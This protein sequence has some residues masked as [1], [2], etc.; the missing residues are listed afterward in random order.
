[1]KLTKF[2][3]F[4]DRRLKEGITNCKKLFLEIK[5]QGF[6]GSYFS[7]YRYSKLL[8]NKTSKVDNRGFHRFE[9]PPGEQAQVDWGS[10]KTIEIN[11]RLERLYCFVYLLGYS[12]TLYIEFAVKK[13]LKTFQQCHMQVFE[14]LG[15]PKNILYDNVKTVVLKREKLPDGTYKF[16]YNPAFLDFSRYYGFTIKLCMPYWPRTKG[17]IESGVKFVRNNFMQGMKFNNGFSSLEELNKRALLWTDSIANL[18]IHGTTGER[19]SDR[20]VEEKDYLH[21]P[22]GLPSYT[23]SPFI[24]RNSTNDGLIQYKSNFYSVPPKFSRRKLF[25]KAISKN[26]VPFIEIYHED[27]MVASHLI[28][29]G[30][31]EWIVD[32]N[33]VVDIFSKARELDKDSLK[34]RQGKA[35]SV[36]IRS[37]DY[38][39]RLIQ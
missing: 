10:F 29:H 33:H 13:D 4:L 14:R 16:H 5:Q 27:K 35:P 18:R 39:D 7:V 37:L 28:Y 20:F 34:K 36:L 22:K 25:I 3:D 23:T 21:F 31:G 12:R 8:K 19:P 9:T 6:N 38:Y 26:G 1:M 30:R 17:K 11:G 32:D 15:I 2:R 24:L